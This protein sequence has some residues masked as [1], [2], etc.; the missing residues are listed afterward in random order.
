M[1]NVLAAG[2]IF[3]RPPE[4]TPSGLAG[5]STLQDSNFFHR[6]AKLGMSH[7]TTPLTTGP[8]DAKR[9]RL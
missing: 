4:G 6:L 1:Q 8:L 5:L 9:T 3:K 2:A 7:A